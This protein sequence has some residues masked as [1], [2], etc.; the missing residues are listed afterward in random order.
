MALATI[1]GLRAAVGLRTFTRVAVV[2]LRAAFGGRS[3]VA[4]V[5]LYCVVMCP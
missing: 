3:L 1:F 4:A 5:V 2:G